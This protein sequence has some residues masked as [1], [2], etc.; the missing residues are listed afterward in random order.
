MELTPHQGSWISCDLHFKSSQSIVTVFSPSFAYW[1]NQSQLTWFQ[2]LFFIADLNENSAVVFRLRTL[3][4]LCLLA[5]SYSSFYLNLCL[6]NCS[7]NHPNECLFASIFNEFFLGWK[8]P[9]TENGCN[10]WAKCKWRSC[11]AG[12]M[13][14][15]R[16]SADTEEC[17][18]M[19]KNKIV[20]N[21]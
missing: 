19:I 10:E 11:M 1:P 20:K 4:P 21:A 7:S 8:P 17:F 9:T 14:S 16:W 15:V 6:P 3:P 13:P 12:H 5:N 18:A 2:T